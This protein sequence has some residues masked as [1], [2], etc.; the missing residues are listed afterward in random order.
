M[1]CKYLLFIVLLFCIHAGAIPIFKNE[2]AAKSAERNLS[3]IADG[4]YKADKL[5]ELAKWYL[6][7]EN[8]TPEELIKSH[9]F[10]DK[11]KAISDKINY[12]KG[13]AD[14][15]LLLSQITQFETKY[16]ETKMYA[17]KA[18]ALF[19][20]L[21]DYDLLGESYIMLWSSTVLLGG[22][23][24][25][26][27]APLKKAETA[28]AMA[29]NKRRQGDTLKEMGD[30]YQ[31]NDETALALTSLEK[32]VA[33]YKACGNKS[34]FG[35]YDLLGTVH[36]A[37]GDPN[38]GIRYGLMALKNAEDLG[39]DGGS[40]CTI[41]NRLAIGYTSIHEYDKVA[42]CL[43][44]ALDI[45]LKIDDMNSIVIVTLNKADLNVN[46]KNYNKALQI[47]TALL[48]KYPEIEENRTPLVDCLLLDIHRLMKNYG[49][50]GYYAARVEKKISDKT[51]NSGFVVRAYDTLI[52]YY[53]D[54]K[55]Y[56][57]AR[58][59]VIRLDNF[60]Q[61]NKVPD[62]PIYLYYKFKID[63]LS[64]DYSKAIKNLQLF[65]IK[66][67]EI[68][69]EKKSRQITQLNILYET[70]KKDKDIQQL[71]QKS[72]TERSNLRHSELMQKITLGG[73]VLVL[74]ILFLLYKSFSLKQKTNKA[75]EL[76]QDEINLKN[77]SLQHLVT[78]KEWLLREIHHRVKNNL[79]MVT[80]LLESQTEFLKSQEAFDAIA[81]SQN[82]IQAMSL[83]H[84]KLYQTENMSLIDMPSYIQEL[85][86]YLEECFGRDSKFR[87]RLDIDEVEFPLS[88]SIPIGL[89]LNE[90]I[91][92]SIKYAFDGNEGI[93]SVSL[94]K[95]GHQD[96]RLRI[97]D[98][99]KGLPDDFD[100]VTSSSLGLRLIQGLS[101]D[102]RA[103]FKMYNDNG[104]CIELFFTLE[105]TLLH[106]MHLS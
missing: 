77:E 84:Q 56:E 34:L 71:K 75:L 27:I 2:A 97:S 96:Y 67:D 73:L 6:N 72:E 79:H 46:V 31:I 28:F 15:Y 30:L 29:N 64:G 11:A 54:S 98:N 90:A 86:D 44:K 76:K 18:I 68:F 14:C 52:L 92:N 85:T 16:K 20:K 66:S 12:N 99:G 17:G 21:K 39:V 102:I 50:A 83:I 69:N 8:R 24:P 42:F 5:T 59:N 65:K 51:L 57:E 48:K 88:H 106:P 26:R 4:R 37:L 89:I 32:A 45:A 80:G 22:T 36:V 38:E 9:R 35:V 105:E 47:I 94:K 95:T 91:T 40:L 3:G 81:E 61:N 10:T 7:K 13:L 23:I 19:I 104:A 33:L 60:F 78:E 53:L 70:G 103:D 62:F 43:D 63:S 82:R 87:Y 1:P 100:I 74:I 93:I 55:Q 101:L 58:K 41:Y 49:L 25:E